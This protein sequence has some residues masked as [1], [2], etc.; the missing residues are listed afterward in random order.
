MP[1]RE[2]HILAAASGVGKTTLMVQIIDDLIDGKPVFD[3]PTHAISPVYLCNDRSRD[4][5]LRTFE[6]V[7]PK[8]EYPV[9]SLLTDPQFASCTNAESAIRTAKT[10]HPD[11]NFIVYDPISFNVENINSSREVSGLLRK[12][13]KLAQELNITILI[14]HHTAKVKTDASYSSPRQK[15]SGSA[16]WGGYSNLNL[17]LEEAE[18]SDAT[19]PLRT[20]HICPRN[21]ANRVYAY[22]QDETGCFV[23]APISEDDPAKQR[24]TDDLAFNALP[25]VEIASY[26]LFKVCGKRTKGALDRNLKRWIAAGCLEK[27]SRGKFLKIKNASIQAGEARGKVGK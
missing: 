22:L 23:P 21:G 18:E 12:L 16:A 27:V 6:R 3:A 4:D 5:I 24:R 19:N 7:G 15:I 26:D 1:V 10:M 11:A 2:V 14:I 17:I 25:L 13:T 9:Y 8:H 20:L